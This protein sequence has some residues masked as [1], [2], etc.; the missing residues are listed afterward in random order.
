MKEQTRLAWLQANPQL[1]DFAPAF[2]YARNHN[3][4]IGTDYASTSKL[5]DARSAAAVKGA[6]VKA[7]KKQA[8]KG[9]KNTG[10]STAAAQQ[11]AG[12]ATAQNGAEAATAA[13]PSATVAP[14]NGAASKN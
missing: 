1:D 12:P 7:S 6:A 10:A 13:S 11:A 14:V 3:D 5:F 4:A 2:T 8:A 9:A